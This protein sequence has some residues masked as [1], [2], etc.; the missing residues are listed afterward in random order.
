MTKKE[1]PRDEDVHRQDSRRAGR[2][3]TLGMA[4]THQDQDGDDRPISSRFPSPAGRS[5]PGRTAPPGRIGGCDDDRSGPEPQRNAR[6]RAATSPPENGL[7]ESN[8]GP[9]EQ[10]ADHRPRH[11][12][13][14][15]DEQVDRHLV[16]IV[17]MPG[18]RSLEA[19]PTP[20]SGRARRG[21]RRPVPPNVD[22][23]PGFRVGHSIAR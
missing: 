9:P 20:C 4:I 5:Q 17:S 6:R 13:T 3:A 11:E 14:P 15:D 12:P 7:S 23:S 19:A 22:D 1:P 21:I 2:T 8:S 16:P 18:D 10:R